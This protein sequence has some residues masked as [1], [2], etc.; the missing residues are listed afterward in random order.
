MCTGR[1]STY[2][3]DDVGGY[4]G[5]C[6]EGA[7]VCRWTGCEEGKGNG[8]TNIVFSLVCACLVVSRIC[9]LA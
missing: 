1:S 8:K 6:Q 4:H 9:E 3:Q 5:V 2:H 7:C